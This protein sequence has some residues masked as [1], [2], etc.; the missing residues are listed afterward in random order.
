MMWWREGS[1]IPP[2]DNAG[3]EV[4]M[5]LASVENTFMYIL[6][7]VLGLKMAAKKDVS[8]SKYVILG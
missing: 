4:R 6:N 5:E 8:I 1:Q 3:E 7:C 2:I